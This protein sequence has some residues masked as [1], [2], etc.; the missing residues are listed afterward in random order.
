MSYVVIV[1]KP[2]Y[3]LAAVPA[4]LKRHPGKRIIGILD[5]AVSLL[6]FDY[7]RGQ[8]M[9]DYP[10]VSEPRWRPNPERMKHDVAYEVTDGTRRPLREDPFQIVRGADVIICADGDY[11]GGA[12]N[13]HNL[14]IHAG[15]GD[16]ARRPHDML[17]Y[18]SAMPDKVARQ[19]EAMG[20]T[21]DRDYI[22]NR[23]G[24]LVKRRFDW[25]FAVNSQALLGN[26][27]RK[28]TG[29]A[30]AVPIGKYGLQL[31]YAM[32]DGGAMTESG[33]LGLLARWPGTG[34][35]ATEAKPTI[36]MGSPIS[37]S[38]ILRDVTGSGLV[39]TTV[40]DVDGR[41]RTTF[42]LNDAG[43]AF[44]DLL[45]PDCRDP[46]LPWRMKAWQEEGL[47]AEP[48]IDRYVRT[49]FGKQKRFAG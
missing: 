10:F 9:A 27:Y 30:L 23:D 49:F 2:S 47:S 15:G 22:V 20:T 6:T 3:A 42:A 38:E 1:T 43:R 29:R 41:T 12:A 14:M 44:L 4:L 25:C 17:R 24:G 21:L 33:L 13:F 5:G 7:P 8:S 36:W 37:V 40:V 45:H 11:Y 35:Y 31:L 19:V 28:A 34:R 32:R 26:A 46:D 18:I 39:D 48:K 16:L